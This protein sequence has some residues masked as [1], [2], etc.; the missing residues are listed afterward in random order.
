LEGPELKTAST[1]VCKRLFPSIELKKP[2]D[3][4]SLLIAEYL[5]KS[6]RK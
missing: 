6:D 2:G 3:G 5:R 4:D 1:E